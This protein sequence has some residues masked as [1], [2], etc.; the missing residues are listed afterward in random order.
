MN[1]QEGRPRVA[2]L[3]TGCSS[4]SHCSEM[5]KG[6]QAG[7]GEGVKWNK[8]L[9]QCA[10]QVETGQKLKERERKRRQNGLT[11]VVGEDVADKKKGKQTTQSNIELLN[12][13]FLEN[14]L[15][16]ICKMSIET[17][18]WTDAASSQQII[19]NYITI[20]SADVKK[21]RLH[22]AMVSC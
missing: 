18:A 2:T 15:C 22:S 10:R 1:S 12:V 13:C 21:G 9:Q 20:S 11:E 16:C 8:E 4:P 6:K 19:L 3:L 17:S 7:G 5:F 14:T